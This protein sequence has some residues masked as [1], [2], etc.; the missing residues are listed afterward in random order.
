VQIFD[1][2][3]SEVMASERVRSAYLGSEAVDAPGATSEVVAK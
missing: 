1:G 2:T 3:P